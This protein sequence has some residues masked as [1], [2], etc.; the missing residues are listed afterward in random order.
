MG[1]QK[2]TL[3]KF[4]FR[5]V[6]LVIL[7]ALVLAGTEK[8]QAGSLLSVTEESQILAIEDGSGK[9]LLKSD[10]FYCLNEDG[11]LETAPAVHYFDHLV[12][13]GT[14]FDGYYYHDESGKFRA[15]NPYM[16]YLN[17]PAAAEEAPEEMAVSFEGYF[18]VNNLGKLTAA[19]QVRYM[20]DLKLNNQ[21]FNGYYYFDEY[22]ELVTETGIHELDMT[23]NGQH[24]EGMYY[25][26][27]ENGL[28]VQEEGTTPE[29]LSVDETGHLKDSDKLGMGTLEPKLT[30][31][32]ESYPGEWSAYVKNLDSGEEI[33]INNQS[34]YSA[35]LIKAFVLADSYNEMENVMAN[36]GQKLKKEADSPEVKV[37]V[38]DLICN[39]ITVSDNESFNEL[40]RLQS[41][42]NDFKEGA[43][44]IN[45]YLKEEGYGD[46]SIQHTLAP[47][48]SPSIGLGGR[49]TTS[50]KDCGMLLERIYKGDCVSKAASEE[51]MNILLQQEVDW[52]IPSGLS[53]DVKVA[54]KT[55]ETDTSQHD[56]AIVYGEKTTYI[57]CVMSQNCPESTAIHNIRDLS[58]VVYYHLNL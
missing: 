6:L 15:G 34:M 46:T 4:F 27:G 39:M 55:G 25:F 8:V 41:E 31:M 35:S 54:N 28:L 50:V 24:F 57:F 58:R 47:S 13:D 29:G 38:D 23:S 51:M 30:E 42:K 49:N 44:K 33:L 21:S 11:T 3:P 10:G 40:V 37:K 14:V 45:E 19:P 36:E 26:G 43:E 12:I 56:I 1:K 17:L 20:N 22:G 32:L 16:T 52:K 7:A 18:M 5:E 53:S 48:A 9:Y 2:F